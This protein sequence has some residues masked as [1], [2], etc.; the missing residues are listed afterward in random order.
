ML[1][2]ERLTLAL[3]EA[4][5]R[6]QES[7]EVAQDAAPAIRLDVPPSASLGDFSSDLA[8]TLSRA[9]G[10]PAASIA[11]SLAA[12]LRNELGLVE[13]VDVSGS[14]FLNVHLKPGWLEDALREAR[15]RRSEFGRSGDGD[16]R[17]VQVEFV[18][19][20][21]TAPLNVVHGRGAAL[22]DAIA[23]LLEWTGWSVTR[24]FYVND[25]GSRFERFARSLEAEYLKQC[26]RENVRPPADGFL[27]EYL[28]QAVR[29][30]REV[31][32]D[33]YL[34]TPP[35]ERRI[36]LSALG[37]DALLERQRA[38]LA[39]LG[40]RFDEWRFESDLL[41]GGGLEEAV[42]RMTEQ[43]LIYEADG[44]L[45]LR[46]TSLGDEADRPL[47]R[48][49]GETTYLAGDLAYHLDKFQ[50]GFERVVDVWGPDH[51]TYVRRTLIGIQAMGFAA[52]NVN[53]LVLPPVTVKI[54]GGRVDSAS[55]GGNNLLLAEVIAN[56]GREAA[57]YFYLL[58]PLSAMLELDLDRA[59]EEPACS[60]ARGVLAAY[61]EARRLVDQ[62]SAAA[63]LPAADAVIELPSGD[64]ELRLARRL[65][66][67][68]DEV[69]QGA[70][71]LDPSRIARYS[72]EV[73]D[74]L[75]SA[76]DA[77]HSAERLALVDAAA[78]VLGNALDILGCAA[79]P[80]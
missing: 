19:A 66:D 69:R 33:R 37:R 9:S 13:R 11:E 28:T 76:L 41:A 26:G 44:A 65:A 52:D 68:P 56:V 49:N 75:R 36:A 24:E 29:E 48:S 1:V 22:G 61:E 72:V 50:R 17:R 57:R 67:F 59:R 55:T 46:T 18:S 2:K 12:N 80:A 60:P 23:N 79:E 77:P 16:G 25:A 47:R 10:R 45:W 62:C 32:G 53:I 35:E 7:G 8:V 4:L 27:G 70:L 74:L 6:A 20:Y 73:A 64:A 5:R 30:I 54:D 78:V 71:E 14:G 3:A 34:D 21:P 38:T 58:T 15:S 43:G 40:V 63:Q 31:V 42:R 51:A 39:D